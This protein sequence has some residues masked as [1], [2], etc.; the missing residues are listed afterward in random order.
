VDRSPPRL[1]YFLAAALVL[2]VGACLADLSDPLAPIILETSLHPVDGSTVTGTAAIVSDRQTTQVGIA[3]N[4][5]NQGETVAWRI[6]ESRCSSL[7]EAVLGIADHYP[8]LVGS[9]SGAAQAE[10]Q[11]N[12]PVQRER[13]YA[14]AVF[15]V[16]S[17]E[18]P[19][20]V[21]LACG[22]FRDF[23]R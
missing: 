11:L 17:S 14:V 19:D 4:G 3:V 6:F 22:S 1:P 16:G 21:I 7:G 12:V 9:A 18:E 5:L 8:D 10:A 20:R 2:A 23:Q 13:D 15:R